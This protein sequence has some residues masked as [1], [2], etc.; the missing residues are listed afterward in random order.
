MSLS[1][2][3]LD[4]LDFVRFSY[5]DLIHSSDFIWQTFVNSLKY[6]D[7]VKKAGPNCSF[8]SVLHHV[9]LDLFFSRF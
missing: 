3:F 7:S 6:I 1:I 9:F 5:G 2:H 8:C 4:Y